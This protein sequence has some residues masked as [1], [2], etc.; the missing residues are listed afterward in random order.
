MDK[1]LAFKLKGDFG[2][3]YITNSG[4]KDV[5]IEGVPYVSNIHPDDDIIDRDS[6]KYNAIITLLYELLD[7]KFK[8]DG[9]LNNVDIILNSI[10][11]VISGSETFYKITIKMYH[12]NIEIS[13]TLGHKAL[14]KEV[15]TKTII[16]VDERGM[17]FQNLEMF[18]ARINSIEAKHRFF[19]SHAKSVVMRDDNVYWSDMCLGNS[20]LYTH[21]FRRKRKYSDIALYCL[22]LDSYLAWE[23]K[24]GGPY[25]TIESVY[26]CRSND[27]INININDIDVD[28]VIYKNADVFQVVSAGS[29]FITVSSD[30]INTIEI[31]GVPKTNSYSSYFDV[32]KLN[33]FNT[34]YQSE[35]ESNDVSFKNKHLSMT[36]ENTDKE[37]LM[38]YIFTMYNTIPKEIINE[39][40]NRISSI[41]N[42]NYE[43]NNREE[44]RNAG[45]TAEG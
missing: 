34:D 35:I 30:F 20:E 39:I 16:N 21:F 41:I 22:Y 42:L 43:K 13:N 40:K 3:V 15:Y 6:F 17:K 28:D 1:P 2:T 27:R 11:F 8:S 19:H 36:I 14:L 9:H 24:E 23:S 31:D 45:V 32:N 7:H 37:E 18:R 26:D 5:T 38:R 44:V 29:E 4:I 12:G 10:D 33:M 25:N